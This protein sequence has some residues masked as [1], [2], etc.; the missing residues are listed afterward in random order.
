MNRTTDGPDEAKIFKRYQVTLH[1]VIYNQ[2]YEKNVIIAHIVGV[3][4]R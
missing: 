4:H 1:I 2:E 3:C